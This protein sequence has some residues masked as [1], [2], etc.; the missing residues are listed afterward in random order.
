CE[1][2][3][4]FGTAS[5]PGDE[6]RITATAV[7]GW[8]RGAVGGA[9]PAHPGGDFRPH[10]CSISC[11]L[12]PSKVNCVTLCLLRTVAM[13]SLVQERGVQERGRS[14]IGKHLQ[15]NCVPVPGS[16][17]FLD[18]SGAGNGREHR[19]LEA[20]ETGPPPCGKMTTCLQ[21]PFKPYLI[22]PTC[23]TCSAPLPIPWSGCC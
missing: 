9:V 23:P 22:R 16:S 18:G 21:H 3:V 10:V 7:D 12:V 19:P 5:T 14:S 20:G 15:S 13:I 6:R 8:L 17:P 1:K 2:A 4:S 11:W